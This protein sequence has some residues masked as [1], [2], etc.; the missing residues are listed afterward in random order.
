[1]TTPLSG[2]F[3]IWLGLGMLSLY[4]AKFEVCMSAITKIRKATQNVENRGS[5]RY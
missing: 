1:M 3:V 2:W 4:P 5:S